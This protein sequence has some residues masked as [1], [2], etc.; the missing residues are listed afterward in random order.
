MH[1]LVIHPRVTREKTKIYAYRETARKGSGERFLT[2]LME[3]YQLIMSNPF[4]FQVRKGNIRHA[5]LKKLKFRLAYKINGQSIMVLELRHT[6]R[7]PSRY[8]P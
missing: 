8:G 7:K 1:E 6:S 5:H 4:V 2:S 3:C